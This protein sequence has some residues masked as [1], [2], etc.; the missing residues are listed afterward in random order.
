MTCELCAREI[1]AAEV[2]AHQI[3]QYEDPH[4]LAGIGQKYCHL[5]CLVTTVKNLSQQSDL[6]LVHSLTTFRPDREQD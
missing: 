6:E 2:D 5:W 3:I 4:P 1:Q